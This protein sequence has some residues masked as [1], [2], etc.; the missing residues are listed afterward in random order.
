M[1]TRRTPEA[2]A[3]V[4]ERFRKLRSGGQFTPPSLEGTIVHP[5]FDGGGEWGGAAFDPETG[6]Y[7]FNSNEM[8]NILRLVERPRTRG[9]S[10]GRGLY[11]EHCATCHGEDLAGTPPEFPALTR[12]GDRYLMWEI[13]QLTLEGRG[14]MPAFPK[15]RGEP[16]RALAEYLTTGKDAAVSAEPDTRDA[17]P[18]E[19]RYT[20]DG[21][22]KFL[23]PDGYP[24]IAPPWG[25][26]NAIDLNKGE[27][28]WKVPLGEFPE[29]AAKGHRNTGTENYGGPL[30]T[31]G[32]LLFIGATNH[33]R[34]FRAFDKRTGELL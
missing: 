1:L 11:L 10:S 29:L 13:M 34:K 26:L 16:L 12:V 33:D 22:R 25:A 19:L 3:A 4:L 28:A 21:Y 5:G 27:I 6:L 7:Y 9:R 8:A 14:R 24:A 2:H 15:L 18:I 30:V 20:L 31:A 17:W 23:D 32:G